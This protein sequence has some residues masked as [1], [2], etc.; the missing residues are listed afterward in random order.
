VLSA[1]WPYVVRQGVANLYR[2]ANQTRAVTLA[3]GFGVFLVA[4]VYLVQ[5]NLLRQ[6]DLG[7]G[8]SR[9]NVI[10]F[11]VQD[12][13]AP[14]VAD[15]VRS[16][17]LLLQSTPIVTMRI[18]S[19][20]DRTVAALVADTARR[21]AGWALRREYRSTFRD[22][23]TATEKLVSGTWF[24]RPAAP[25]APAPAVSEVSLDRGLATDL[26][27][28]LGDTIAWDVQGVRVVTRLTSLRDISWE[29]FE[30]NFFAV[31]PTAAIQSA[32]KQYAVLAK[33]P[34]GDEIAR[35]QR[36]VV[37]RYPNVSSIDLSLVQRT[38]GRIVERVSLAIRFLAIF[39]LATGIPVLFSAVAATRRDRLR[40]GVLLKTLGAT[41]AQIL[42]VLLAEYAVLGVLGALT[43]LVLA[44]GGAWGLVHFVF[45]GTF[46][47]AW[48]PAATIAALMMGVTIV[49]GVLTARDVFRET[50]MAALREG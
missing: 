12:D 8:S 23:L 6:F 37:A 44:F 27:L 21:R 38:I 30:L 22:T 26:G 10:L 1:R 2:P 3:L 18:A 24:A 17:G 41:R 16:H 33:V 5:S 36:D 29:R 14:T 31:F 11:D 42:R 32:P 13:Q 4:T 49:I 48:G 47:P 20:N 40:E 28:K 46:A 9:A 19:I 45:E 25:G 7:V 39:S 35:L 50:P 15:L 43:G 34:E